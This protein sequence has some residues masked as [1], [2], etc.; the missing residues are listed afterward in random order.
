MSGKFYGIGVGPGDPELVTLKAKRILEEADVIASP[1]S[2]GDNQ[3]TAY[4]IVREFIGAKP[5][6]DL[7]MPMVHNRQALEE[8]WQAAAKEI[9]GLL[10][11]GKNIAFITLGDPSLF[12]TFS[13]LFDLIRAS[14][15]DWEIVPGI[16][17]AAATAAKL[18]C[19]LADG[20]E[21]LLIVAAHKDPD[22]LREAIAGHDNI[23]LMKGAGKWRDIAAIIE[24]A[25]L[26]AHTG[27]V[28][29][30][31]MAGE[32]V[33]HSIEEMPEDL[34]YFLTAIIRKGKKL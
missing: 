4:H 30:C 10:D 27:A 31:T 28:E 18:G 26:T 5:R 32:R 2:H 14:G 29:R 15:Y 21:N 11:E 34:S 25:G 12:S 17:A 8:A 23:V 3:S 1:K 33:F 16:M 22:R 24:E 6:L 19:G 9:I 13:Y 20:G 7:V